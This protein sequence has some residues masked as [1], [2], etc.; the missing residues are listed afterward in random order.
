MKKP[1]LI[2]CLLLAGCAAVPS[3]PKSIVGIY[4]G[5]FGGAP[6]DMNVTLT[7]ISETSC[8]IRYDVGQLPPPPLPYVGPRVTGPLRSV[9]QRN[10]DH[11]RPITDVSPVLNAILYARQNIARPPEYPVELNVLSQ[12]RDVLPGASNPS[13]CVGFNAEQFSREMDDYYAVCPI[14]SRSWPH[15]GVLFMYT[16]LASCG[17]NFCRYAM[18][19]LAR[20]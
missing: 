14:T 9:T 11:G 17:P 12:L 18:V 2:V 10:L 16:V 4:K 7:C 13:Q 1:P 6:T 19:P 15:G 5:S 20:E 3:A 8:S